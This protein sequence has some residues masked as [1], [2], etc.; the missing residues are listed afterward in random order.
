MLRTRIT[1]DEFTR[2][3]LA[4]GDTVSFQ[5]REYRVLARAGE[6]LPAEVSAVHQTAPFGEGI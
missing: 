3:H 5:I 2:L 4:Q 6:S 1:K